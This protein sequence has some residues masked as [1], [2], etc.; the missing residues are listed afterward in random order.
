MD[1]LT[2]RHTQ[3]L[4]AYKRLEYMTKKFVAL[5]QEI[6]NTYTF[7]TEENELITHRDSLIKRFEFCYD[8]TWKFLK[9]LLK[10]HYSIDVT[11]PRK[12]FQECAQQG[13]LS[14]EEAEQLTSM[15]DDRN[16]T[17]HVYDEEIADAISKRIVHYYTFLAALVAK[18]SL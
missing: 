16:E 3:L 6:S 4:Q 17:A 14:P 1:E 5:S 8:L 9:V 10:T 12:V 18:I 11:S 7:S 13:L 2:K 15:I